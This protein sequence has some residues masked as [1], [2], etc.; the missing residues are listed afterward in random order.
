MSWDSSAS[1]KGYFAHHHHN[2][3][4]ALRLWPD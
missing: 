1:A 4:F 3:R 2:L